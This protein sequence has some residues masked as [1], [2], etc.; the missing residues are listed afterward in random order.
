[1]IDDL[2]HLALEVRYLDRARAFYEERLGLRP[3]AV[4]DGE[5]TY[6]L[7]RTDLILRRPSTVPRGALHLHYALSTPPDAFPAWEERL[8][9][10]DPEIAEFGA[11]RSLYVDDPDG[12][13]VELGNNG[14]ADGAD[15]GGVFEVVLEV[16]SLS[17]AEETYRALGFEPVDRGEKRRRVRLRGP[18]DLELWEPQL[19]IADA[20]GGV[21][22]DLGFATDDPTGAADAVAERTLSRQDRE[23]G[24]RVRDA[25]GHYLTFEAE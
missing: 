6:S 21:H 11:Y 7:G 25:D 16:E 15:P 17:A 13:C 22:V 3:D 20:R 24:I 5:V 2:S 8:A 1:M 4:T 9:D 23:D 14:E 12:H 19:G 10:L 18:F